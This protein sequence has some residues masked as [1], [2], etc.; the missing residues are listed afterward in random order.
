MVDPGAGPSPDRADLETCLRVMAQARTAH[1]A[2]PRWAA[3]HDA[4]AHLYRAGKKTQ[5]AT[6]RAE[7]RRLDLETTAASTRYRDQDPQA[8][9]ETR[10]PTPVRR[11]LVGT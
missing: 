4:A 2:D 10:H 8:G 7:R 5:K 9:G 11:P 3:V 1:P 6:R